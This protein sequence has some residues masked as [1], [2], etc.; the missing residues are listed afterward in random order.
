MR[1]LLV[2]GL[3]LIAGCSGMRQGVIDFSIENVKNAETMRE[4]SLDCLYRFRWAI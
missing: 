2:I 4:V 3:L 1:T